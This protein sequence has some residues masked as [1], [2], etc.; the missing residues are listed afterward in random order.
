MNAHHVGDVDGEREQQ[1]R[2]LQQHAV[3]ERAQRLHVGGD[4][5]DDRAR[6][7]AGKTRSRAA[8]ASRTPGRAARAPSPRGSAGRSRAPFR[9]PRARSVAIASAVAAAIP[10]RAGDQP[11][12]GALSS[13][14][15]RAAPPGSTARRTTS[16]ARPLPRAPPARAP[17]PR[18][19]RRTPPGSARGSPRRARA[20]AGP[21]R[22]VHEVSIRQ[23]ATGGPRAS[24]A[25]LVPE[26]LAAR[27]PCRTRARRRGW[28]RRRS[29]SRCRRPDGRGE[30]APAVGAADV[31]VEGPEL[32][33]VPGL[34][35]VAHHP[36]EAHGEDAHPEPARVQLAH[37]LGPHLG[38][39][40]V[41][42]GRRSPRPR[43]ACD[44]PAGHHH[45]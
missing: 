30:D 33:H 22:S 1:Q 38:Q 4:A 7:C 2:P 16:T 14:P 5:V 45:H 18:A 27:A 43:A 32:D 24:V 44:P 10:A 41:I 13:G 20:A 8:A 37:L 23:R 42:A 6:S 19:A 36:A 26:Q 12:S 15:R 28:W 25:G 3:D 34:V 31:T 9:R 11:A 40:V 39:R 17:A 21:V 29:R 35:R